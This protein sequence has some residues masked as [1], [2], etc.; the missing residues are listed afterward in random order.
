MVTGTTRATHRRRGNDFLSDDPQGVHH[1]DVTQATG[2]GQ[3][4]V[5][6]LEDKTR[7]RERD[8][9]TE[10]HRVTE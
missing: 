9:Q 2:D 1:G 6:I 8:K 10:R 5:T 7:T 3:S 4:S